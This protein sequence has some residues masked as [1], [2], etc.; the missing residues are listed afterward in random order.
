ML[1][2]PGEKSLGRGE[3]LLQLRPSTSQGSGRHVQFDVRSS[4]DEEVAA[5]TTGKTLSRS[6]GQR[7]FAESDT[8]G[9]AMDPFVASKYD[10]V[11]VR[12]A[13]LIFFCGDIIF[14]LFENC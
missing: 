6:V 4:E 1:A 11:Y 9:H 14:L 5:P 3:K 12:T 2:V 13:L 10:C 7:L 8:E